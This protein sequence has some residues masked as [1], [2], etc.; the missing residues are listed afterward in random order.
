MVD[1]DQLDHDGYT[2]PTDVKMMQLEH[3][4]GAGAIACGGSHKRRATAW[5][6]NNVFRA[7]KTKAEFD[8]LGENVFVNEI[9]SGD[10]LD[11]EGTPVA[12]DCV[13]IPAY[14]GGTITMRPICNQCDSSTPMILV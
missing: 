12:G 9:T 14:F 2:T 5:T 11:I 6:N 8:C 13:I 7:K 1:M 4:S 3:R 10:P